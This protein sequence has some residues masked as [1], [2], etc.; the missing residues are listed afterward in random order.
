MNPLFPCDHGAATHS[1]IT[2]EVGRGMVGLCKNA[3]QTKCLSANIV[4]LVQ[5]YQP[6]NPSELLSDATW[7]AVR[8]MQHFVV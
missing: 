8:L 4:H 2:H 3:A 6:N 7:Q 1:C 5:W